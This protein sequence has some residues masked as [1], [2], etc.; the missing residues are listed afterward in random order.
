MML[1]PRACVLMLCRRVPLPD[2]AF[3]TKARAVYQR[4]K[5]TVTVPSRDPE[6]STMAEKRARD[7]D[8]PHPRQVPL[9]V[10]AHR[11][12]YHPDSMYVPPLLCGSF[13]CCNF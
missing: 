5:L 12:E 1:P 13:I 7:P 10:V 4:G 8:H 2:D 6:G 11:H 3:T 9:D